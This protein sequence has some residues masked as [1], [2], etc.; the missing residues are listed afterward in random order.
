M[1]DEHSSESAFKAAAAMAFSEALEKASPRL[2]EPI[3]SVE[4]VTPTDFTGNVNSDLTGTRRGRVTGIEPVPGSATAQMVVA[5]VPLAQ[6]VGY[7]TALRSATQ[8]RASY[9]MRLSHNAEVSP[10]LQS[11]IVK[12]IRGY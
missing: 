10:A 6:M 12:R 3:M 2:L 8:G 9:A 4:V 11:E 5:E 7:A 1:D